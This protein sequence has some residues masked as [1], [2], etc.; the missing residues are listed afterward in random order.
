MYRN[1]QSDALVN[2]PVRDLLSQRTT[3]LSGKRKVV[4]L[5]ASVVIHVFIVLIFVVAT[6][7]S[8]DSPELP[9]YVAV[10]IIPARMLGSST[11]TPPQP[12]PKPREEPPPKPEPEPEPPPEPE[13][14]VEPEDKSPA[15][16]IPD[17]APTKPRA[18]APR[19]V[20]TR[21]APA[22][23]TLSQP[24]GSPT[25]NRLSTSD[26]GAAIGFDN[27]DFTYDYYVD[28]ML[29]RLREYW[30]RPPLGGTV[31]AMI[32]FRILKDGTVVDVSIARSSGYNSFDLAA[33]RAVQSASP[34]P[35]L[36]QSFDHNSLGVNL[37]VR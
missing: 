10:Q 17:P 13:P 32:R 18:K 22:P 21:E 7:L 26:F 23:G 15:A 3:R 19:R 9:N 6:M 27:P 25:G 29:A 2:L 34:L 30:V 35:H 24:K 11:P 14:I 37:V 5:A 16:A 31:E 12:R 20:E 8:A 1:F 36:P 28:Q 4:G 33:L